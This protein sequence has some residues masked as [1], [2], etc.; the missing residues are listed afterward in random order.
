VGADSVPVSRL[1]IESGIKA[2]RVQQILLEL[3]LGGFVRRTDF[4]QY[5]LEK[6]NIK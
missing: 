6:E 5:V 2:R 4:S 3:E 1:A